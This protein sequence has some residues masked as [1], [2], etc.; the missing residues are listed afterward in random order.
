[1]RLYLPP[2]SNEQNPRL[3]SINSVPIFGRSLN[4]ARIIGIMA[5]FF[6]KGFSVNCEYVDSK[7]YAEPVFLQLNQLL[8]NLS[9]AP[10]LF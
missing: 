9:F 1:M 8:M 7:F 5:V 2:D 6:D 10:L 4:A 3:F